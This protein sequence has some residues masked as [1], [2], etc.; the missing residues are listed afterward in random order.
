MSDSTPALRF[1]PTSGVFSGVAGLVVCA[2][3]VVGALHDGVDLGSV[4][5]ALGALVAAVLVWAY[6]LR[7]RIVIEEGGRTLLLR[8]PLVDTRVPL[9]A[10]KVVGV[11]T[12]TTIKTED[13]RYDAVAV[14]HSVRRLVRGERNRTG[15]MDAFFN[16]RMP[17]VPEPKGAIEHAPRI[18][19]MA[20]QDAMTEQVLAAAD[21][22]RSRG[23]PAE[24]VERHR[25]VP[26]LVALGVLTV[27][28]VVSLL[29]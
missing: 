12:L 14:G 24:P 9:A 19:D 23:L 18:T 7:P 1:G 11:R 16:A 26:E 27:A 5:V 21:R 6:L 17:T 15:M 13:A 29:L 10:V 22:A 28:F 2:G 3:F 4:R 8:N 25:A 20:V